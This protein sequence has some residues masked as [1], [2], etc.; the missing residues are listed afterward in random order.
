MVADIQLLQGKIIDD[1]EKRTHNISNF[2]EELTRE[3][4]AVNAASSNTS[5]DAPET[6]AAAEDAITAQSPT[7]GTA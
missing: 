1:P 3:F 4:I 6:P 7:R 5:R 2:I